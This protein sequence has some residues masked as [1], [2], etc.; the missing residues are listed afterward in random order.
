[1]VVG[2]LMLQERGLVDLDAPVAKWLPEFADAVVGT[3]RSPGLGGKVSGGVWGSAKNLILRSDLCQLRVLGWFGVP[4]SDYT[5][6]SDSRFWMKVLANV[7]GS[8]KRVP[9]E[10]FQHRR[11]FQQRVP[12]K[13]QWNG[14]SKE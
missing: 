2:F 12:C 1:M 11:S 5:E 9:V 6:G 4:A 3:K 7:E 10:G 14:S 13:F 8:S